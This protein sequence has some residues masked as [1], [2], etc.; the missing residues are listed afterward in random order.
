MTFWQGLA[1]ALGI[2]GG[3]GW[4]LATVRKNR[5]G[6]LETELKEKRLELKNVYRKLNK[7][8]ENAK[9]MRDEKGKISNADLDGLIDI[10]VGLSD[11]PAQGSDTATSSPI[12]L[13]HLLTQKI[14]IDGDGLADGVYLSQEALRSLLEWEA[15]DRRAF[16]DALVLSE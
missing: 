14:D 7:M 5:I 13:G 2:A 11:V 1:R 15:E 16:D 3:S 6:E 8:S 9:R 4:L 10:A 12:I